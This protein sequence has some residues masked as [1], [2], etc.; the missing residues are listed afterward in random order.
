MNNTM[1][2]ITRANKKIV[3][4]IT[5]TARKNP[6]AAVAIGATGVAAT[7]G[8]AAGLVTKVTTI[9]WRRAFMKKPLRPLPNTTTAAP[10][11][12]P[13]ATPTADNNQQAPVADDQQQQ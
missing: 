9:M 3:K 5:K 4:N 12:N 1:K 13:T 2:T 6:N 7:A 10:T 8:L 11:T